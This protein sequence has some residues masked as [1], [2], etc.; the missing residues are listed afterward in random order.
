MTGCESILRTKER[1]VIVLKAFKCIG[2]REL[3]SKDARGFQEPFLS[4]GLDRKN[5]NLIVFS[6]AKIY[7]TINKSKEKE[8]AILTVCKKGR[9]RSVMLATI[10]ELMLIE[11]C[12]VYNVLKFA[13]H[14]T[15]SK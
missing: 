4:T 14:F 9:H 13:T 1:R 8:F 3:A 2:T 6:L 12:D 7:D 5:V 11:E 15:I 10:L